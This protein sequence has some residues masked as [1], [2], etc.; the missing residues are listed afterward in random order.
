MPKPLTTQPSNP[1]QPVQSPGV[2]LQPQP[3]ISGEQNP[4]LASLNEALAYGQA[5]VEQAANQQTK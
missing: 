1:S 2:D 5:I 4:V 3:V